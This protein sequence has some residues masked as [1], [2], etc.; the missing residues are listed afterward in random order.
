MFELQPGLIWPTGS[1]VFS[2]LLSDEKIRLLASASLVLVA[3]ALILAGAG[4]FFN[5]TWWRTMF[6]IAIVISSLVYILLWNGKMK[7]LPDQGFVGILINIVL[8]FF[9]LVLNWP[10]FES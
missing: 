1:W 3:I 9:I 4:L 7:Q 2:N 5:Q 8:A 10:N 6:V